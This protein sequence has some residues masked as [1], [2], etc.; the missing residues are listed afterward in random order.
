MVVPLDDHRGWSRDHLHRPRA[1]RPLQK[2]AQ[3]HVSMNYRPKSLADDLRH[4]SDEQLRDLLN[5][6]RDLVHPAP[7]DM[8]ALT[9]RATMGPSLSRCLDQLDLVS[10][11][12]LQR[13]L[14]LRDAASRDDLM[15]D[16]QRGCELTGDRIGTAIDEL[17]ALGLLWGSPESLRPVTALHQMLN[18]AVVPPAAEPP[19]ATDASWSITD[20]DV[21][22]AM[23]VL[24]FIDKAIFI[25]DAWSYAPPVVLRSGG[26]PARELTAIAEAVHSAEDEAAL[27]IECLAAAH[28]LIADDARAQW[29]ITDRADEWL[30][31]PPADQWRELLNAWLHLP[32]VPTESNV[33]CLD[34]ARD[35]G[36]IPTT[37]RLTLSLAA[38]SQ[39]GAEL[40][41]AEVST[42]MDYRSP[43]RA[44]ALRRS[45]TEQTMNEGH[46]LGLFAHGCLTTAARTWVQDFAEPIPAP[47]FPKAAPTIIAQAD[48]TIT[49]TGWLPADQ[50]RFLLAIADAESRGVATVFRVSAGSIRRGMARGLDPEEIREWCAVNSKSELPPTIDH[51]I[52][53]A[54]RSKEQ[55]TEEQRIA[56]NAAHVTIS[57]VRMERLVDKVVAS[58]RAGERPK[59]EAPLAVEVDAMPTG[60]VV[61][62]LRVAIEA[63]EPVHLS[64][65]ESTG[66]TIVV[67]LEPMRLGGGSVTGFDFSLQQVRNLAVS[68]IA[69]VRLNA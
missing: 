29:L 67:H 7:S 48:M 51:L 45:I 63:H 26:L 65:A 57:R 53:D 27:V 20:V 23:A 56:W 16:V 46:L 59:D 17:V 41:A 62:A 64:Y 55:P 5:R 42:L 61:N 10:T 36:H 50:Q 66:E 14:H 18:H 43:R 30:S 25:V 38:E 44:S 40:N 28:L 69:G 35:S 58:L 52:S 4:R 24:T 54:A 2:K 15:R 12:T 22:A 47:P 33:R 1:Q 49:A 31:M 32:R 13:A 39:S 6:R 19:L 68:R 21:S 3:P 11:F 34:A 60:A 8:T 37:R 9:T